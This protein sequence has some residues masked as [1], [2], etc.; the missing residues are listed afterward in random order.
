ME[1]M[2]FPRHLDAPQRIFFFTIDQ[3]CVFS[4]LFIFGVMLG[5]PFLLSMVGI[6]L[7]MLITRYRDS[8]PD[9]HAL[10]IGWWF[11]ILPLTGRATINPFDREILPL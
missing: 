4:T 10:H 3:I 1:Q 5:R 6:V 2:P 11:G 7:A 9:G 8:R